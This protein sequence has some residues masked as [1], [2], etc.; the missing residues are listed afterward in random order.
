[1]PRFF[2]SFYRSLGQF[3]GMRCLLTLCELFDVVVEYDAM[4]GRYLLGGSACSGLWH[5]FE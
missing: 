4:L 1:M 2:A 3:E 5:F